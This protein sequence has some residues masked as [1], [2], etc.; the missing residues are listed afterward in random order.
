MTRDEWDAALARIQRRPVETQARWEAR[1]RGEG[2]DWDTPPDL[3]H[4]VEEWAR[5]DPIGYAAYQ[6][7]E[8]AEF[9]EEPG[10]M[11]PAV[12]LYFASTYA[13]TADAMLE[14]EAAADR[15]IDA[16]ERSLQWRIQNKRIAAALIR[17]HGIILP[18]ESSLA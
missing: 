8:A 7:R 12:Q 9:G 6:A 15:M 14:L 2:V 11:Q 16:G 4:V 18:K 5:S 3:A 1:E 13:P 17:K 10:W